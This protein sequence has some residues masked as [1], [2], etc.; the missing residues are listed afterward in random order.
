[1]PTEFFK[2]AIQES[3]PSHIVPFKPVIVISLLNICRHKLHTFANPFFTKY[4]MR[5][6]EQQTIEILNSQR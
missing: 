4:N 1:M 2:A 6:Q 3:T 5:K